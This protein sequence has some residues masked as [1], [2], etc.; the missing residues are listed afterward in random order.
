MAGRPFR[1]ANTPSNFKAALSALKEFLRYWLQAADFRGDASRQLSG[2]HRS[3]AKAVATAAVTRSD[4][5]HK[6]GS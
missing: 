4:H 2:V 1:F 3:S 6:H 5:W